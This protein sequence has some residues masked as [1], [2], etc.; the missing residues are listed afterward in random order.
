MSVQLVKPSLD[1]LPAYLAA[2]QRGFS[3]D[4]VRGRVAAEEEIVRIEADAAAFVDSLDDPEARGAPIKMPDGTTKP[5]LPGFRRWI[6]DDDF[7]GNINFRW[8]PGTPALP[9]H[10]LGHVGYAVVPWKQ[11]MGY[12]KAGLKLILPEARVL[13]LPYIEITTD[14]ENQASQRVIEA[15]GGWLVER[16]Q[17]LDIYGGHEGLR[18]RIDL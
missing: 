12:A 14:P 4:T 3:A 9:P 11:S 6:W 2:L 1:R 16:F 13:G 18:Y 8:Q 15:C 7:C 17:K 10:V 5:R